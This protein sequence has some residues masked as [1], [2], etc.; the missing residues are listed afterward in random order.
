[1]P[2][3]SPPVS[4]HS[5]V[6]PVYLPRRPDEIFMGIHAVSVGAAAAAVGATG[7]GAFKELGPRSSESE[8]GW[9]QGV[10]GRQDGR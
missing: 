4:I 1:M 8:G 5:L 9:G 10:R 2:A 3:P 6:L 7:V